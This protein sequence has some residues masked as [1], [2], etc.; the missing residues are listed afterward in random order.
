MNSE[1]YRRPVLSL[2]P[3]AL[4]KI[5]DPASAALDLAKL[6]HG[7]PAAHRDHK[8]ERLEEYLSSG[9]VY[10]DSV[11][12]DALEATWVLP[13]AGGK[14]YHKVAGLRMIIGTAH[15]GTPS[16][17][18]YLTG[19]DGH[20]TVYHGRADAGGGYGDAA[21]AL[22]AEMFGDPWTTLMGHIKGRYGEGHGYLNGVPTAAAIAMVASLVTQVALLVVLVSNG[23]K[24][25]WDLFRLEYVLVGLVATVGALAMVQVYRHK[26]L[27]IYQE[28]TQEIITKG[29]TGG[30]AP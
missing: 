12:G 5:Y 19:N 29:L 24:N 8:P 13:T 25:Y 27:R 14:E 26:G 7:Q 22:W 3:Q 23:N 2:P 10:V 28:A 18:C 20:V 6:L 17:M 21:Q 16:I 1:T 4:S 30:G 11:D 15:S 9:K